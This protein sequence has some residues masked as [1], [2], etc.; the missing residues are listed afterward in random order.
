MILVFKHLIL[1]FVNFKLNFFILILFLITK[2]NI[3]VVLGN[4]TGM[5]CLHYFSI[6]FFEGIMHIM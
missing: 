2:K 5:Q 4:N 6:W 1:N 3:F